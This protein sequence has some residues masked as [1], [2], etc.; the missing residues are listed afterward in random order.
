MTPIDIEVNMYVNSHVELHW[1]TYLAT[2]L[3]YY[4]NYPNFGSYDGLVSCPTNAHNNFKRPDYL[5]KVHI[6]NYTCHGI[7]AYHP[8]KVSTN[9]LVTWMSDEKSVVHG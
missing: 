6:Q 4:K 1:D 3:D 9:A 8:K 2:I 7:T 5:P